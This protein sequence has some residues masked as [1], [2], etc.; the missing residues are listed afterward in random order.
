M[1]KQ[2]LQINEIP[3]IIWGA[4]AD[5]VYLY[6]H[7]QGGNKNEAE[8]FSHI[9]ARRGYQV[10]S[11][12]LPEHGERRDEGIPMEPWN[13]I[14]ELSRIM[15]YSR[16]RWTEI[17]LFA[18]SIGAWFSLL[19]FSDEQL[20]KS[21]FVSPVVNMAK[22]ISDMMTWA[23]VTAS[24]LEREKV[25][26]VDFGPPLSW[27]YWQYAKEH[28]VQKWNVPTNILYGEKDD[29]ISH[30][31]IEEFTNRFDC[32]LTVMQGGEHWFHTP[33]QL[34]VLRDWAEKSL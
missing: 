7:G 15:E 11:I 9:A 2:N 10:M 25:I 23:N 22:L 8:D 18:N 26:P 14:P 31:T 33:A 29:L 27:R 21:L 20:K 13:V 28:P 34:S 5:K 30:S 4:R 19:A 12:D 3:A 16:D 32:S 17:S 1:E 6:I 24:Q